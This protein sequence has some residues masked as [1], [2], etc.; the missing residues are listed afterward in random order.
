MR[1]NT[2]TA[3][4]CTRLL[5]LLAFVFL[6]FSQL[7]SQENPVFKDG[8][9]IGFDDIKQNQP[10]SFSRVVSSIPDNPREIFEK[11]EVEYINDF[12][13][14]IKISTSQIWGYVDKGALFVQISK[15]FH[16]VT[17]IGTISHLFVNEK[18][19]QNNHYDPYYYGYGYP[20]YSPSYESN[21]LVQYIIDFNTGA[22]FPMGLSTVE[23]L[24]S[25]DS[26]LY[27]EFMKLK[28]RKRKQMML[29]YIRRFNESHPLKMN[30]EK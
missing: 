9:Y 19:V 20:M 16:R 26:A 15:E 21:R 7:T 11:N 17:M 25:S 6:S 5:W 23:T 27:S 29:M 3:A 13:V 10:I 4:F 14:K 8:L 24:I 18:Y 22:V 28:K 1:S 2:L 12:G 30:N